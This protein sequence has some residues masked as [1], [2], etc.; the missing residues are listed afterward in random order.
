MKSNKSVY[1]LLHRTK[2]P[3]VISFSLMPKCLYLNFEVP[4]LFLLSCIYQNLADVYRNALYVHSTYF[5]CMLSNFITRSYI[6][7][8][9]ES[10][11]PM[12]YHVTQRTVWLCVN[13]LQS[14]LNELELWWLFILLGNKTLLHWCRAGGRASR[15]NKFLMCIR[16]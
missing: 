10:T 1:H 4:S 16:I 3:L 2:V 13:T 11:D 7:M 12:M 15:K 9:E 14:V 8:S 6:C 5:I